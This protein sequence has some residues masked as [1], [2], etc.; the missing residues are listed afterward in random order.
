[1]SPPRKTP[2]ETDE[3]PSGAPDDVSGQLGAL[4]ET[5]RALA[6]DEFRRSERL[7]TK[8]RNQFTATGAL[9][10]VVMATTAGVLNALI[11]EDKVDGW[12]YPLLGGCALA[13][14]VALILALLWSLE[15]W[16]LRVTYALDPD[17]VESYIPYAERGNR[18]VVIKLIGAY[19]HVSKK[20]A[21]AEQEARAGAEA[22]YSGVRFRGVDV[23][24]A[25]GSRLRRAHVE[26][27]DYDPR[28]ETGIPTEPVGSL[29]R[30][31]KLNS[32]YADYDAGKISY[33]DLEKEQD[34]AVKE[35]LERQEAIGQPINSDGDYRW[36]S[37]AAYPIADTLAGTGLAENL[38]PGGQYFAIFADG[39]GRQLPKLTDGPLKYN[40][41]A[42]DILTKS[43]PYAT[44][45]MKQAVIAP[46]VLALL[47]PLN[48]PVPGYSR[49]EFEEDIVR[50]CTTDIRKAFEAGAMHVS[51][52]FTEG[53]L[54]TRNPWTGAG[55][56]PHFID[57]N[58]R[59][60]ANFTDEERQSIGIHTCPG[61][62]RYWLDRA[63]ASTDDEE[64]ADPDDLPPLA[65]IP[66][67]RFI[68][69]ED[70]YREIVLPEMFKINAGYFL[71]S[72][73][74]HRN[75]DA[76]LD[77][78][79]RHS[80]EDQMC[81]LGVTS[82]RTGRPESAQEICDV[83]VHASNFIPKERLATTDDCAFAPDRI[84]Q[85]R[86][87]GL[88]LSSRSSAS[89]SDYVQEI[90]FEKIA[91]RVEGTRRAAEKLGV[92]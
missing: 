74:S 47:Y 26:V 37:F 56:L 11:D 52:D 86:G 41:Y 44:R 77:L 58:N 79:G 81:Y 82:T 25:A 29:P 48:D 30:P 19:A 9:F 35:A 4:L 90:A 78:I 59:V 92:G 36:S 64:T 51:I 50:E 34:A 10:A 33:E 43:L 23:A 24:G 28:A 32:A 14:I 20:T 53:R 91:N 8:S 38:A 55:L 65:P 31:A 13:T 6:D 54:A 17:T 60:L 12:V 76:V 61:G 67:P 18:A 22:G 88:L 57:L 3:L 1:M 2:D 5:A 7:D 70:R 63:G 27:T 39:S 72:L 75:T 15:T 62:D 45:P 89:S 80:R 46:S 84:V 68:P 71:I 49:E 42:A 69:V 40:F 66:E 73:G 21:G 87:H 85:E 16:R 83:L